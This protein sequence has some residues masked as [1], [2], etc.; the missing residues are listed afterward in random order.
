ME[1]FALKIYFVDADFVQVVDQELPLAVEQTDPFVG[2]GDQLNHFAESGCG[3][4]PF[5][6]QNLANHLNTRSRDY[7][8]IQ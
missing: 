4:L 7:K 2:Q 8:G 6:L 1:D 3:H 5:H